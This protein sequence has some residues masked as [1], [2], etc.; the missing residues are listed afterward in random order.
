MNH[1][2]LLWTI[3]L[4]FPGAW[5]LISWLSSPALDVYGDMVENYA[6]S[7]T[8]AWGSF[9]HPPLFAWIV[10]AWFSVF[11]THVWAYY[12]L[13][14]VNAAIGV[15][16]IL[17]LARMWLPRE[18]EPE[19][20]D[21]YLLFVLLFALLS[22]P[23]S[24]LAAKFNADTILLSLWPW[25]AFAFFA[26][27]AAQSA[28][29]RWRF[30]VLLGVTG[31]ASMLGKYYSGVLLTA[32]FII[33]VTTHDGRRWYR[34]AG[35]YVALTIFV[36]LLI[37]HVR[38]EA[39]MNFPFRSYYDT[40]IDDDVSVARIAAFLLS[41]VYYLP[42]SWAA[43]LILRT[44]FAGRREHPVTWRLPLRMLALLAMLPALITAAF[45]VFARVHLTTHWAIPAWFALPILV[46]VWTL[47]RM[48]QPFPWHRFARA[49]A[50]FLI[51]LVAGG[52]TYTV[53]LSATGNP[54]Y[55]LAREEMVHSIESRFATRYP[56]QRLAWA[57]G[58][59]PETGALSFFAAAHPR[60][61]PGF[62]DERRALVNPYPEWRETY[63]VIICFAWSARGRDGSH[64]VDCENQTRRWLQAHEIA[65]AEETL[66]Y[67]AEGWQFLRP[68]GKNVTVFWVPPARGGSGQF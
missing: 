7:Q 47:P 42:L 40:K 38:W 41:G 5:M 35:P 32:L 62:P 3:G 11:P 15:L 44:R 67:R 6:W 13:S 65:I 58:N 23:Y 18:F 14:Y 27:L 26:A 8:L 68:E 33:S 51:V 57:G 43:W 17:F 36:L 21:L 64:D 25:T 37:P 9:K 50:I 59:W 1:R 45:N 31:A 66:R 2:R 19:R 29:E 10:G 60:G 24:N 30:A 28:A 52:L 48:T 22:A 39:R 49:V 12:L 54:K 46:A 63:G 4:A 16:G 20:R 55:S 53:V 56:G 34:T 61:L